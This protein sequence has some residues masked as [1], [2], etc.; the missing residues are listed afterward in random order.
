MKLNWFVNLNQSTDV[1]GTNLFYGNKIVNHNN[2]IM[3]STNKD[4]YFIDAINGT[5]KKKFNFSSFIKPILTDK[6]GLIITKNN[7]LIMIDTNTYKIIYSYDI[8]KEVAQFLKS[9][10][11]NDL[12]FDELMMINN[13][14]IVFLKNSFTLRFNLFG[15]LK[16]IKKLPVK[17]NSD[18]IISNQLI[19]YL[20]RKNKLISVN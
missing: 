19:L 2:K 14:I 5:I 8:T 3:I 18:P 4:T 17:I 7:Y 20:S 6:Y 11:T 10:K 15:E 13:N 12:I 1:D 16:Y 9:K